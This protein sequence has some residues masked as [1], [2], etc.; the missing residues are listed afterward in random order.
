MFIKQ[1]SKKNEKNMSIDRRN[2]FILCIVHNIHF[3]EPLA[4]HYTFRM[5]N[6]ICLF[7]LFSAQISMST[8]FDRFPEYLRMMDNH[9]ETDETHTECC[10]S[11]RRHVMHVNKRWS[12]HEIIT[13]TLFET[14]LLLFVLT[15]ESIQTY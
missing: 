13:S 15:Q 6:F 10:D 8:W 2:W 9:R 1:L 12:R 14:P 3:I 5:K 11:T 7:A 4:S